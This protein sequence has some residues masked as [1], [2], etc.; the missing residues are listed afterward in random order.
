LSSYSKA[1]RVTK[2]G[3]ELI[4]ILICIP[5]FGLRAAPPRE[6]KLRVEKFDS[7]PHGFN[8]VVDV[9]NVGNRPV[10]LAR[11]GR[12]FPDDALQSLDIQQWDS[13]LGWQYIGP[14]HDI[15]PI[16]TVTLAPGETIEDSIP[17]GDK[18]HGWGGAPCPVRIAH[19]GGKIRAILYYAY[20]SETAF[21]ERKASHTNIISPSI[22]L[23]PM[24]D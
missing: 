19:L 17:I 7:A 21:Q 4:L 15:L 1:L 10:V 12:P 11:T 18:A 13:D 8:V 16:T 20:G 9:Q 5:A 6:I 3:Y 14:C 23:P 22:E 2:A 24:K